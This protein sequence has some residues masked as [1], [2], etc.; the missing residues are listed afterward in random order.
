MHAL[1]TSLFAAC[2]LVT[3]GGCRE[4]VTQTQCDQLVGRFAELVVRERIPDASPAVVEAEQKRE[5]EEAVH[6]DVLRNCTTE[7]QPDEFR[8]AMAAPNADAFEKCLE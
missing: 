1:K 2:L 4:R 6:E 5:R 8:C 3:A 7:V